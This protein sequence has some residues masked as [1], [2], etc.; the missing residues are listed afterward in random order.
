MPEMKVDWSEVVEKKPQGYVE[1][2]N[3][4]IA[5][6]GPLESIEIDDN[7]LVV[8]KLRWRAEVKL[9]PPPGLPIED[10]RA[11]AN[12]EPIIFP[13]FMVPFVIENTQSKGPRVRFAGTSILYIDK[14][15]GLDPRRVV[16]LALPTS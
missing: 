3:G 16:G 1:L 15:E 12:D 6:H 8:I 2:N 13:N 5:T 14:V 9:G 11:V 7:D 10:W 4:E